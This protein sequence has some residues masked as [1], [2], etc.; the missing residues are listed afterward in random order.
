MVYRLNKNVAIVKIVFNPTIPHV[1]A[2]L[3]IEEETKKIHFKICNLKKCS[4]INYY[5]NYTTNDSQ[6]ILKRYN[7]YKKPPFLQFNEK[8][9]FIVDF[10]DEIPFLIAWEFPPNNLQRRTTSYWD[11]VVYTDTK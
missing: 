8:Y 6:E 5:P 11:L 7:N 4:Q 9:F 1:F 2:A 10:I 3:C